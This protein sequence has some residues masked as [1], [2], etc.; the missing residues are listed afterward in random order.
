MSNDGPQK[1][2]RRDVL[3]IAGAGA[4]ATM[5]PREVMAGPFQKSDFDQLVSAD[6]KLS[7]GWV[8]S[9]YERGKPTEYTGAPLQNIGMPIGGICCGLVYLSGDGRLWHWDIFN[10]NRFGV[11]D[12]LV[13]YKGDKLN[14]GG[15]NSYVEPVAIE[16]PFD[17]G[18]TLMVEGDKKREMDAS[19]WEGVR[20]RG[21]YPI[22]DVSYYD[23][24]C[25]VSVRLEAFSP[26]IPLD[27]ENSS[28]PLTRLAYTLH[29][30]SNKVV[31]GE[32][33]ARMENVAGRSAV[34][35][36][37]ADPVEMLV[38]NG[39]F[40]TIKERPK[41]KTDRPEVLI[42]DWERDTY[43]PWTVEG[44]AF[45]KGPVARKDVIAY[46]GNLG[47]PGGH[48]VNTHSSAPADDVVARDQHVGKITS[49]TFKIE[50][51]YIHF[52]IGGGN[53]PG[54]ECLN[55]I[56]DGKTVISQTGFDSNRMRPM[57][58]DISAHEG[59]R[60]HIE[61]VDTETGGWGQIGVGR[62]WQSDVP[63]D[64]PPVMERRD[65]G[66]MALLAVGHDAQY[67]AHTVSQAFELKPNQ[68]TTLEFVVAWHF[69]NLELGLPDDTSKRHYA[70]RFS[71]ALAV[72][73]HYQQHR[74]HLVATTRQWRDTWYG[75]DK[76]PG[77][78]HWFLE[79]TIANASTLATT[80]C[81]RMGSGRFYAFEGIG[82]CAGT[83]GHVWHYAQAVA[84]LF[85]E[86]ERDQRERVDLGLAQN[87]DGGIGFRAEY[88]MSAAIDGQGGT[89]CRI[90]REHQMSP[91][92]TFLKRNWKNAK[93][94]I[95]FLMKMDKGDGIIQ[96][97]QMNTLDAAWYGEISWITSLYL[98]AL[99]AGERMATVVGDKAFAADCKARLAKGR[100]NVLKLFNGEYFVQKPD[101]A[102]ANALGHYEGC[103]ADQ[104]FGQGWAHQVG[105]GRVLPE[106][107]TKSALKSL[108]KYNFS[109]D[110]GPWRNKYRAGRWYA[111]AGEAGLIMTTNP[112]GLDNPYRD[113]KGTFL[114]YFNE[115][116][117]GQEHQVAGHMIAEGMVEEGLALVRA[118]HDRH[119]AARRSPYNEIECSDHYARA[120]ASYGPFVSLTG[121][122]YDGPSGVMGFDLKAPFDKGDFEFPFVGAEGWGVFGRRGGELYLE[123]RHGKL[124]LSQLRCKGIGSKV[125]VNRKTVA[126]K[127]SG[128]TLAF[129][130]KVTVTAGQVLRA[131]Y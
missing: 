40:H 103:H 22:G 101:T 25:S 73:R 12:K 28:Y 59:K 123:V 9:L 10:S 45:G 105:L 75:T 56:V 85:P 95:E 21:Q 70:K 63:S 124:R 80:V 117:T 7:K 42:E 116:W 100:T 4:V 88:D 53:H 44:T 33:R 57:A 122:T 55:L 93:R 76:T 66:S 14:S 26:F 126:C 118:V 96:G 90:L 15:G 27:F 120:M 110:V 129:S 49:P 32:L 99:A 6:K 30:H 41:V 58:F 48:V 51:K 125:S 94:A 98:A 29:N 64:G 114:F 92:D 34:K 20:F 39:V 36:S 60:A 68:S 84:R 72:A 47:G 91:D 77:L 107:E 121:F 54:R 18:V 97:E 127:R 24:A 43:A 115:C 23:P 3:K 11:K 86:I 19:G 31:K 71:D 79:R 62:I 111:V 2:L 106:R 52:W 16:Q 17:F 5:L 1:V 130:R 69:P 35:D 74:D 82:C 61:I 46:Q 65:T 81:H 13:D 112:K 102:H 83:C 87:K 104:V 67:T 89:I 119:N 108:W 78:P 38:T 131:A 37:L 50:R 128:S 109:P 113:P 8:K